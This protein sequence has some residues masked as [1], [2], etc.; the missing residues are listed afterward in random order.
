ML[1]NI[2]VGVIIVAVIVGIIVGPERAK[3]TVKA[4]YAKLKGGAE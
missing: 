3:Q 4:A 1:G 2:I